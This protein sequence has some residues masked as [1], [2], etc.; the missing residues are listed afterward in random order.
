MN[1][2]LSI[3]VKGSVFC[4]FGKYKKVMR[5]FPNL[6]WGE[7]LVIFAIVLLLFGAK[8]I[9]DLAQGLGKSIKIFKQSLTE[10]PSGENKDKKA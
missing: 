9:P 8:R 4:C 5:M 2:A 1:R 6:G 3:P 7:L 10:D